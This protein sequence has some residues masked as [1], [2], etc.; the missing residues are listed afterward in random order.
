MHQATSFTGKTLAENFGLNISN[1]SA[2]LDLY[3]DWEVNTVTYTATFVQNG[4]QSIGSTKQTCTAPV[5][6]TCTVTTPTITPKSG[7]SVVGWDTVTDPKISDYRKLSES[8]GEPLD[9]SKYPCKTCIATSS[10][11]TLSQDATYYALT[12]YDTMYYVNY[13]KNSAHKNTTGK[14]IVYDPYNY[15]WGCHRING[16]SSCKVGLSYDMRTYLSGA[17][18]YFDVG[19][20]SKTDNNLVPDYGP[21]EEVTLTGDITVYIIVIP[22][23]YQTCTSTNKIYDKS[24][25][26]EV[27]KCTYNT[28]FIAEEWAYMPSDTTCED[29]VYFY[30]YLQSN[31]SIKGWMC[32]R[33]TDGRGFE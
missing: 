29:K 15:E 16:E 30:G 28:K 19:G 9:L 33:Y 13:K 10:T 11:I 6:G 26:A 18:T 20:Y 2:T 32:A 5:G 7:F 27:G 23:K 12:I 25:M 22:L 3:A 1:G 21:D 4:A 31:P 14:N 17:D 8:R 24:S